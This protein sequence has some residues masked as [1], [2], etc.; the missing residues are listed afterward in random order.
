LFYFVEMFAILILHLSAV[1]L[2][3]AKSVCMMGL[4][5]ILLAQFTYTKICTKQLDLITN[6]NVVV[7]CLIEIISCL[8]SLSDIIFLV[9]AKAA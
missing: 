4:C 2:T 6:P 8:I 1:S 7:C 5:S 9:S 3:M